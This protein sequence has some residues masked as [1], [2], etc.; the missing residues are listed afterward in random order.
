MKDNTNASTDENF[1]NDAK[2][3]A[4][5]KVESDIDINMNEDGTNIYINFADD[6]SLGSDN[7]DII[8]NLDIIDQII[9]HDNDSNISDCNDTNKINSKEFSHTA[10]RDFIEIIIKYQLF[11]K[12]DDAVLKFMKKYS[13]ISRSLCLDQQ[14][15]PLFLG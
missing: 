10:Y 3:S 4:D 8:D 2:T 5:E 11:Y 6:A 1:E 13:K 7:E 15:W 9:T 12:A 14:R